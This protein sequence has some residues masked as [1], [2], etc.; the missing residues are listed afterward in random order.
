MYICVC[1]KMYFI[2][3][4]NKKT[5]SEFFK[6]CIVCSIRGTMWR[7]WLM[8]DFDQIRNLSLRQRLFSSNVIIQTRNK[9]ITRYDKSVSAVYKSYYAVRNISELQRKL[10]SSVILSKIQSQ[11]LLTKTWRLKINNFREASGKYV[12]K[13]WIVLYRLSQI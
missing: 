4:R 9:P 2:I 5:M 12:S 8:P 3:S 13:Q 1:V 11:F 10:T 6:M 7:V